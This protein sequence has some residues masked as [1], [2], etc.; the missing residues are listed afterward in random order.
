MISFLISHA[1]G[2]QSAKSM[3]YRCFPGFCFSRRRW[4][5]LGI[6]LRGAEGIWVNAATHNHTHMA[7]DTLNAWIHTHIQE[8]GWKVIM[9]FYWS[10]VLKEENNVLFTTLYLLSRFKVIMRSLKHHLFFLFFGGVYLQFGD[11]LFIPKS[12]KLQKQSCMFT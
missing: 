4:F 9:Y 11:F 5:L 1:V 6:D 3:F 8:Q 10:T 7:T 2:L 12:R